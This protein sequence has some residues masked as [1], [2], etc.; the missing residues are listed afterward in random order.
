[1]RILAALSAAVAAAFQAPATEIPD[2]EVA[3]IFEDLTNAAGD[4]RP[5]PPLR[6]VAESTTAWRIAWFDPTPGRR[7]IYIEQQTLNVCRRGTL[8][9]HYR[10]CIAL[11]LGHELAHFY[12]DH[13]RLLDFARAEASPD[14]DRER[15]ALEAQADEVGAFYAALAGYDSVGIA[16]EVL[17]ATYEYFRVPSDIPGYPGLPARRQGLDDARAKLTGLL[18][19]FNAGTVLF[20]TKHYLEAA[21][22]FDQVSRAFPSRELLNNSGVARLMAALDALGGRE[23]FAFPTEMDP[24]SRL[25]GVNAREPVSPDKLAAAA[26][27][28]FDKAVAADSK[29]VPAL[30]NRSLALSVLGRTSE[31]LGAADR[32]T[33]IARQFSDPGGAADAAIAHG[34]AVHQAGDDAQ[35]RR[36]FE[37]AVERSPLVARANLKVLDHALPTAAPSC[38]DAVPQRERVS[39]KKPEQ[40]RSLID[41]KARISVEESFEDNEGLAVYPLAGPDFLGIVIEMQ[42][43]AVSALITKMDYSG[44]SAR[45]ICLG[46]GLEEVTARY[47]CPG[48][49]GKYGGGQFVVYP[50]A[51]LVLDFGSNSRVR[52][53]I[54]FA[55][56]A[57]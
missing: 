14:T 38:S 33:A 8:A 24:D 21:R 34:I 46:A 22:C 40:L 56:D 18:P 39:G 1:M 20:L 44:C 36:D 28:S 50:E 53:W 7:A 52:R 2:R 57:L 51:R 45:S 26:L 9:P 13:S 16:G 5:A 29:Y 15:R 17:K 31:A 35:A 37:S 12:K 6:I 41:G 19:L 49:A 54:A 48:M 10:D 30:V 25:A 55:E 23:P 4:G 11:I 3:A 43:T 47:A 32:A 42:R 27:S